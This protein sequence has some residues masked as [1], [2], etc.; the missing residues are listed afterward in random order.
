[1]RDTSN[2]DRVY[3]WLCYLHEQNVEL[4]ISNA[5]NW[6]SEHAQPNLKKDAQTDSHDLPMRISLVVLPRHEDV[7]GEDGLQKIVRRYWSKGD[8]VVMWQFNGVFYYASVNPDSGTLTLAKGVGKMKRSVP[9]LFDK[10]QESDE[11][12]KRKRIF[13]Q[14]SKEHVDNDMQNDVV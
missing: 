8:N 1:M 5:P 3:N 2:L 10:I 4:V 14:M 11:I 13:T 7:R 9:K 12:N 6:L